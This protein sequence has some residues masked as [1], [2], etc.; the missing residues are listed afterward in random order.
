MAD[1]KWISGLSGSM[2]L[3]DAARRVFS[4]RLQTV[5]NHLPAALDRSDE[6]RE[7]VHQLRV[8]TRRAGAALRIFSECFSNRAHRTAKKT[9][10]RIRRAAGEAR[11]WDVFQIM[12]A[13][14]LKRATTA[15]K[16]TYDFLLGLGQGR[17]AVAQTHLAELGPLAAEGAF[18]ETVDATL[19][20]LDET[21]IDATLRTQ[22]VPQL[23]ALV[24]E[25]DAAAAEDLE[26]YENLHRVRIVGKQLRYAMEIFA[27][28]FSDAFREKIYP[29]VEEMQ[30]ILGRANDSF[31]ATRRLD[32]IRC[33]LES[34]QPEEWP[35]YRPG[36][37]ALVRSHQRRL[38]EQRR[39]FLKW[40]QLWQSSG[41]ER[42]LERMLRN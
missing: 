34:T 28:C 37:T 24:R 42:R 38:P 14:K 20:S 15:H 33:R 5:A 17:R 1:D 8:S 2:K 39:Q 18:A 11:D 9:M 26:N 31:V 30:E 6:D 3:N 29:A 23:T 19:E 13:E 7:Y 10:R 32:E 41:M 36:L 4:V 40:W 16:P 21:P 35:R 25:L 12:I 22:A 27:C